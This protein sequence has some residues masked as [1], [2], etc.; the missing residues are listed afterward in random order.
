MT[1]AKATSGAAWADQ[2]STPRPK[3]Q[4]GAAMIGNVL[5]YYDFIVYAFLAATLAKKFFHGDE[6]AGLLASFATF[7]VGFLARPL[8]G[9]IIGRIADVRGRKTAL[10]ITIFGMA[11]GTV[12]I[13]LLPT[14]DTIGLAAPVLLVALR[15]IQGLAAGGEWGSAT[16]LIVES[17]PAGRRGFFGSL[18][19]ASIAA[20]SLL[21][22][23]VVAGMV[24]IFTAQQMDDWGWRIPF[25]LGGLLLPVGFYMRRNLEETPAFTKLQQDATPAPKTERSEMFRMLGRAFGFTIIWT[26]SYYIMLSYMPTFLVK[27]A[28][29]TQQQALNSNSIALVVLVLST[30][31]FGWL[32]DRIGRRTLLLACC[33]AFIILPYPLFNIIISKPGFGT[34]L[35]IQIIFNLFIG[36]FSGAAP[37]ALCEIFPTHSRTTLLSIGYSLATAIFGGFA[38]FIATA[39]IEATGSSISPT[40]YLICAGVVSGL[41]IFFLRE[42]AHDKLK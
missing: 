36:A 3:K 20:S 33:A 14:Y 30:P 11:L 13:G 40:Y 17:A 27:H 26:V 4:L 16:T 23:L 38:P 37:A 21:S 41:V 9:A 28:G 34:I 42:T 18:G 29:L 12:G 31:L 10:Q 7:G 35:T 5:E 1:T 24:G 2:N 39:L 32:S 8:G 25:L 6:V 15:L 22:S 19:Q